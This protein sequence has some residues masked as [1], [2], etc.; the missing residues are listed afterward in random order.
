ME[1]ISL[2]NRPEM[3]FEEHEPNYCCRAPFRLLFIQATCFYPLEVM[4]IIVDAGVSE[5]LLYGAGRRARLWWRSLGVYER[6]MS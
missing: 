3:D 2:K 4:H 5:A 6:E 1:T